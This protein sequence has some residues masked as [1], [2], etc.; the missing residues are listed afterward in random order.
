[1]LG[2]AWNF[3][4]FFEGVSGDSIEVTVTGSLEPDSKMRI[5]G[6]TKRCSHF[7]VRPILLIGQLEKMRYLTPHL[8]THGSVKFRR[9]GLVYKAADKKLSYFFHLALNISELC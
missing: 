6:G 9:M 8:I 2:N 7:F 1:M 5:T 3:N 4:F